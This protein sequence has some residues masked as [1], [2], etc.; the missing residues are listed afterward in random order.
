MYR[1]VLSNARREYKDLEWVKMFKIIFDDYGFY[2]A[3][4]HS[5]HVVIIY[6]AIIYLIELSRRLIL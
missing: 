6:I 1:L 5:I 2:M 3:I 4:V